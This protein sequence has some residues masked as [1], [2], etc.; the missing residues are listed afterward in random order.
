MSLEQNSKKI[1]SFFKVFILI[2]SIYTTYLFSSI[3]DKYNRKSDIE[4]IKNHFNVNFSQNRE[5]E[6]K[7]NSNQQ[8]PADF[9]IAASKNGT[10]Y[11]Y[12]GCSGLGRIK[13]E[14]LVFFTSEDDAKRA[15][16]ELAKNCEKM[17][18]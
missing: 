10:K 3:N 11:Y 15:G 12:Q 1:K 9:Y 17:K 8:L 18:K 5:G 6:V 13:V 2:L 7:G 16:L 14:N 4:F